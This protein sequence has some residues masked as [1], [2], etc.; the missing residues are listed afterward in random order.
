MIRSVSK[1]ALVIIAVVLIQPFCPALTFEPQSTAAVAPEYSGC[2]DSMPELPQQ[3]EPSRTCCSVNHSQIAKP[4][5]RYLAPEI[6]PADEQTQAQPLVISSHPGPRP[7][8][9]LWPQPLQG[10]SVILRI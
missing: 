7:L 4:A 6:S 9:L 5:M 2:H 1:F 3:P 8:E 10:S